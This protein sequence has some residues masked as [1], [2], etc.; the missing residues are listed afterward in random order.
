MIYRFFREFCGKGV[1]KGE[2]IEEAIPKK[3]V[4]DARQRTI[5]ATVGFAGTV[6]GRGGQ[7]RF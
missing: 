2:E 5:P 6:E 1:E 4:A 3:G 7:S